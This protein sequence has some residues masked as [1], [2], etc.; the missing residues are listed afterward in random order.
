MQTRA[1]LA[2]LAAFVALTAPA[3]ALAASGPT[4]ELAFGRGY[5]YTD[6]EVSAT[7]GLG[8]VGI[9]SVGSEGY[10]ARLSPGYE[11]S[12]GRW[13]LGVELAFTLGDMRASIAGDVLE[14]GASAKAHTE[15]IVT[16]SSLIGAEVAPGTQVFGRIGYSTMEYRSEIRAAYGDVSDRGR[17]EVQAVVAGAGFQ[18]EFAPAW[19]VRCE[20]NHMDY[21]KATGVE[22]IEGVDTAKLRWSLEPRIEIVT[23]GIV[24]MF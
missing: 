18:I 21:E 4:L 15:R 8:A 1:T 22:K 9:E 5:L 23:V 6:C 3:A 2:A 14:I 17:G 10:I 7:D 11:W 12:F 16:A 20:Y 19:A 13:R 24:R